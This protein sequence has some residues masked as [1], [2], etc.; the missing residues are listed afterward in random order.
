MS[1]DTAIPWGTVVAVGAPVLAAFG[2]ILVFFVKRLLRATEKVYELKFDQLAKDVVQLNQRGDQLVAAHD[3][4]R[5]KWDE[6]LREYLKIDST[7]GQKID[8]LFRVVDQMQDAVRELK[9]AL[10]SKI[11]DSFCRALSE[12]KV[13][14]RDQIREENKDA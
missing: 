9:P 8:A 5:D 12:L 10:N 4:I 1:P 3:R 13:Y 6:F 7:R 11:E 14:V 2:G